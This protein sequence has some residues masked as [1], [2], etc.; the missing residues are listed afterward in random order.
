M[1]AQPLLNKEEEKKTLGRKPGSMCLLQTETFCQAPGKVE[2][3]VGFVVTLEGLNG[4]LVCEINVGCLKACL[5]CVCIGV[6]LL[7]SMA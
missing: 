6:V 2:W 7:R 1:G 4:L 3:M 5:L